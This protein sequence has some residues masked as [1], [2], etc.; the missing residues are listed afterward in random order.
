[1]V[2][3]P[4]DTLIEVHQDEDYAVWNGKVF[5]IFRDEYTLNN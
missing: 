5:D 4:E 3:I 1:M 2:T